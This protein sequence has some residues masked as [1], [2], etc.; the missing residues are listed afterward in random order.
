MAGCL[1][2]SVRSGDLTACVCVPILLDGSIGMGNRALPQESTLPV[3][4]SLL[5]DRNRYS[6]GRKEEAGRTQKPEG[7]SGMHGS[8]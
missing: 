1:C 2:G 7:L 3:T 5:G 6:E 4:T 8:S